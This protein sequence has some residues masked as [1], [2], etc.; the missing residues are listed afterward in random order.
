M[1]FGDPAALRVNLSHKDQDE[2]KKVGED[3]VE[4]KHFG[5]APILLLVKSV[6]ISVL[7]SFNSLKALRYFQKYD[8]PQIAH[9]M[10]KADDKNNEIRKVNYKPVWYIIGNDLD[11]F[12]NFFALNHFDHY[13]TRQ[14]LYEKNQQCCILAN[15][16]HRIA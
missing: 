3:K 16:D 12:V 11:D 4:Q 1:H 2:W 5:Q 14:K 7:D 10:K 8:K 15:L 6:D 13:T 9:I